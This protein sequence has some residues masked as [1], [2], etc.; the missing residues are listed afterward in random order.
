M[1]QE[2]NQE[3]AGT[4]LSHCKRGEIVNIGLFT[5]TYYPEINGVATS[6]Y[7]LKTELEKRGHQVYVFTTTTPGAPEFEHNVFRVK[8][9]PCVFITERRVGM[10]YS[11]KLAH[12]IKKLDLDVIHTHTEF[13]L[14]VFGRIMARELGLPIVHTYH[15]I[16]ED[17]THYVNK[18]HI[19]SVEMRARAF[20][21]MFSKICC[22]T[23]EKVI[24]PT[25][26]V[27]ELLSGYHVVKDIDVIPT[28]IDLHKFNKGRY[29]QE[30]IMRQ[31]KRFGIEED[32]K[33][34]LYLGRISAEK[35][36]EE[37]LKGM[38]EYFRQHQDV[39]F[40]IVG[41]GPDRERLENLA[42]GGLLESSRIIFAGAQPWDSIGLFYQLGDVFVSASNSETQGLTYIEAMA[43]GLPVVAKED[44]CLNGILENGYNGY[45]FHTPQ[46]MRECLDKVLYEP[47]NN[48]Y[49]ANS[50]TMVQK[51]STEEFAANV[52]GVYEALFCYSLQG[53]ALPI[54]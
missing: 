46:E 44:P 37:V 33:I 4:F 41:D 15:T 34:I 7:M 8:S 20:V 48:K 53:S 23:V 21:R 26:K 42:G 11:S 38:P 49:G 22:N 29:S 30:D 50:I 12:I 35:N 47:S 3:K 24:V 19:K 54:E 39:K 32:E 5:E 45:M 27:K 17:Y 2:N 10:F 1:L 52:E 40:L 16:Y 28:G 13:S 9:I 31:R 18:L 6:V 43:S 51:Y 36:I 25:Q 14:G